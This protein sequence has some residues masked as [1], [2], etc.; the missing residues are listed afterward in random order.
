MISHIYVRVWKKS[1]SKGTNLFSSTINNKSAYIWP[2]KMGA[3]IDPRKGHWPPS[4]NPHVCMPLLSTFDMCH[5]L[6]WS[7]EPKYPNGKSN[8][9][10]S[11]VFHHK[12][13]TER[14][15]CLE[16]EINLGIFQIKLNALIFESPQDPGRQ[17]FSTQILPISKG[18]NWLIMHCLHRMHAII[19]NDRP[20]QNIQ[21]GKKYGATI[22]NLI[23]FSQVGR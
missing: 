14:E 20:N 2:I 4:P 13:K 6:E 18:D 3:K 17:L 12:L 5:N 9:T 19:Q 11:R 10:F 8:L 15:K 16:P 22:S 21:M 23:F 1:H 7:S